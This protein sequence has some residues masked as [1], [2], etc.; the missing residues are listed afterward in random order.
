MSNPLAEGKTYFKLAAAVDHL[1]REFDE[2]QQLR[3]AVAEAERSNPNQD[4]RPR[5]RQLS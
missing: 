1:K 4:Q 3:E 2:L 5:V